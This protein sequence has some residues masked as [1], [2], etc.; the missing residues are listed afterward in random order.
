MS[1]AAAAQRLLASRKP[2]SPEL[3]VRFVYLAR[4]LGIEPSM[5]TQLRQAGRVVLTDDGRR[6]RYFASLALIAATASPAHDGVAARHDDAK[7]QGAAEGAPRPADA[8]QSA[9]E[10]ADDAEPAVA[11]SHATRRAKAL[12]DKAEADAEAAIRDNAIAAGKLLPADEVVAAVSTAGAALRAAFEGFASVLGPQVAADADEARC[13][14]LIAEA[15]E[16]ALEEAAR[17]FGSLAKQ[18]A[19]A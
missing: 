6:V 3:D 4:Q 12:A 16:H 9:A 1:A 14:A 8:A 7:G 15:V 10:S 2:G 11:D 18:D 19:T 17:R 5:V 13:T